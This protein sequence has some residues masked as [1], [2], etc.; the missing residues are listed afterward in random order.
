MFC[1]KCGKEIDDNAV[2]C[3]YCGTRFNNTEVPPQNTIKHNKMNVGSIIGGIVLVIIF[4]YIISPD[5]DSFFET[6]E[7]NGTNLEVTED[8]PCDMGY[9]AMGVCGSVK[10]NS[11]HNIGYAQVEIN[12]YNK[13]GELVGSTMDNINNIEANSVWKFKAPIIEENVATYKIKNVTGY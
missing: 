5:Y 10:N 1:S 12:L 8:H 4:Y 11:D 9:G 6:N 7:G 2:F 3:K 13:K